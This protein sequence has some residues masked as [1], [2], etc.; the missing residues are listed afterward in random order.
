MP[1]NKTVLIFDFDGT[2]YTGKDIFSLLP[3]FVEKNRRQFLPQLT[4]RQYEKIC[5]E[6]PEWLNTINGSE[7][8]KLLISLKEKYPRYKISIEDFWNWQNENPYPLKFDK[9][10]LIKPKFIKKL[11]EKFPVYIVSNSAPTHIKHHMKT[12]K[13]NPDWF[14]EIISNHFEE[15]DR[16]KQHYYEDILRA[17]NTLPQ[18][19]YVFGDSVENDLI[20]AEK[21]GINTYFIEDVREIKKIIKKLK[22]K[23]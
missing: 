18:N 23:F 4:D 5:K 13:L 2:F 19:A 10:Q 12:L 11:C 17:E 21:I 9:K 16:T 1:K 15:K 7:T 3:E 6:C 14:D 20:P 22:L 8:V